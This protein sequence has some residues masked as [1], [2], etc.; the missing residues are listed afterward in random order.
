[1]VDRQAKLNYAE[2]VVF[3]LVQNEDGKQRTDKV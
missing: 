3:F 2:V 1:M